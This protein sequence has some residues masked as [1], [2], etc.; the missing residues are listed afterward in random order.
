V[1]LLSTPIPQTR[2]TKKKLRESKLI[3]IVN[4]RKYQYTLLPNFIE[5]FINY[6]SSQ[7]NNY[8]KCSKIEISPL[9]N[10]KNF[11]SSE[12]TTIAVYVNES[13]QEKLFFKIFIPSLVEDNFFFLNGN[14]YI[15]VIYLLDKP[16]IEKNK[17][18]K[19]YALFNSLTIFYKNKVVSF[20]GVNIPFKLFF[21]LLYYK[22]TTIDDL[23]KKKIG[24]IE[25]ETKENT[26]NYFNKNIRRNS[27]NKIINYF[28]KLMFDD[29]TYNLYKTSYNMNKVNLLSVIK[30]ALSKEN[31]KN[32]VD[33]T[34]KRFVFM[35][36]ILAPI[37]KKVASVANLAIKGFKNDIIKTDF[38]EIVKHFQTKLKG[39]FLYNSSNLLSCSQIFKASMISPFVKQSPNLSSLHNTHFKTIC[40][41]TVSS[42]NPGE[43]ISITSSTKVD[44]FGYIKTL[45]PFLD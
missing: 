43:I 34:E 18:T 45:N 38:F 17:S 25:Y 10:Y 2:I 44:T 28:N 36:L 31:D 41:I 11:S 16:I 19:I 30:K 33:L 14:Y 40:P 6:I 39:N 9:I 29:Y 23:I 4:F 1:N 13:K 37:I 15:P 32:F 42:D 24:Y 27:I 26:L 8:L 21:S 12:L 22:D 7:N 35:E 20:C 3:D 5:L